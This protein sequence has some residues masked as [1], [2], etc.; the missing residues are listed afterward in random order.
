MPQPR[1]LAR[2]YN[3]PSLLDTNPARMPPGS[4]RDCAITIAHLMTDRTSEHDSS[5]SFGHK[6]LLYR[7]ALALAWLRQHRLSFSD[8]Q[9]YEKDAQLSVEAVTHALSFPRFMLFVFFLSSFLSS[10]HSQFFIVQIASL[11]IFRMG[12]SPQ[13]SCCS[14]QEFFKKNQDFFHLIVSWILTYTSF[15]LQTS[16]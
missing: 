4:R 5:W 14:W 12:S 6:Q 15:D 7:L 8:D 13:S 2:W 1:P 9:S 3:S 11:E 16:V 10:R